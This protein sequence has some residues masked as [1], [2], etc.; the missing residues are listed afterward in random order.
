[1][2]TGF[3]KHILILA[4][5]VALLLAPAEAAPVKI[6]ALGSSLTQ[7]YGLPPGTE[8]PVVL[9]AALKNEQIDKGRDL[10]DDEALA[11]ISRAAK[12]RN[13]AIEQYDKAGRPELADKERG[14]LEI[15]SAY[16]PKQ[17]G[18]AEIEAIVRETIVAVGATTKK[19]IG[20]VMKDVMAKYRGQVDGK[21]VQEVAGRLLG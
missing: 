6:L 11:V 7:G 2:R 21:K 17:L 4:G 14:E 5:A 3:F 15:L 13:E 9:Q 16:L 1:M 12:Q 18:E 8:F 19:D 10:E 20:A